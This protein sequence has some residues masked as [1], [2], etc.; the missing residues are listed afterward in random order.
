MKG[1]WIRIGK[2]KVVVKGVK[3]NS[4]KESFRV[5][6]FDQSRFGFILK[7]ERKNLKNGTNRKT[8]SEKDLSVDDQQLIPEDLGENKESEL[9]R[10]TECGGTPCYWDKFI[11]NIIITAVTE[12]M[13]GEK[14]IFLTEPNIS[15]S[16][17]TKLFTLIYGL[18]KFSYRAYVTDRHFS[19]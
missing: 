9:E 1:R 15:A 10:Y 8:G 18:R 14:N 19:M 17:E 13:E 6:L 5:T 7:L 11:I 12:Q 3:W 16:G 2:G 4:I